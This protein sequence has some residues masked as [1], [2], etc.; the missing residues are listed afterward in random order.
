[1]RCAARTLRELP[2]ESADCVGGEV[3]CV[4]LAADVVDS[5]GVLSAPQMRAMAPFSPALL[6]LANVSY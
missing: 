2:E 5:V 1:M 4:E 3:D 6:P